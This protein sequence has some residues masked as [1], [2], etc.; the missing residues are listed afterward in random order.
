MLAVIIDPERAARMIED[1]RR[2][3]TLRREALI[4][5]ARHMADKLTR[6]ADRIESDEGISG[7]NSLGEL[8][9]SGVEIDRLCG[10]LDAE[11]KAL[12]RSEFAFGVK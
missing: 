6:M 7:Y 12:V 1:Q 3:V 11:E 8:Q 10:V 4:E 9:G 2:D 5:R